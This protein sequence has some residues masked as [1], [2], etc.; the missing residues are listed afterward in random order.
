MKWLVKQ[1]SEFVFASGSACFRAGI[2][3]IPIRLFTAPVFEPAFE[4]AFEPG[5]E[6]GWSDSRQ[7]LLCLA[8]RPL[9]LLHWTLELCGQFGRK[10]R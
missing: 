7:P 4:P 9:M 8:M 5:F 3:P 10:F 2:D 6:S 1:F